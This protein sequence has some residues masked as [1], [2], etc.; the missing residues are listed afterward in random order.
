[1]IVAQLKQIDLNR[2]LSESVEIDKKNPVNLSSAAQWFRFLRCLVLD[3][4]NPLTLCF[5]HKL[6]NEDTKIAK[7]FNQFLIQLL[8]RN[9]IIPLRQKPQMLTSVFLTFTHLFRMLNNCSN[10]VTIPLLWMMTKF[11]ILFFLFLQA[12]LP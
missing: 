4:S 9:L 6:F 8:E 11:K 2:N 12:N 10:S 7:A 1:M 3:T 5:Q